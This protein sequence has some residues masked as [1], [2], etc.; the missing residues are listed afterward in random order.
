MRGID[1]RRQRGERAC[2]ASRA[3]HDP[4]E[5]PWSRATTGKLLLVP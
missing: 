3:R 2:R 4:E 5:T 1:D